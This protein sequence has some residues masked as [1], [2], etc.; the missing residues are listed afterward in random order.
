VPALVI[1][2]VFPSAGLFHL[3]G[4]TI[5]SYVADERGARK[6]L[7]ITSLGTYGIVLWVE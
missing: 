1:W 5:T 3:F 2:A 7:A 4:Q 6:I